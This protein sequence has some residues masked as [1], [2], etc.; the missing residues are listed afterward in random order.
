MDL[1]GF[2]EPEEVHEPSI[3]YF[4]GVDI[5]FAGVDLY[6]LDGTVYGCDLGRFDE[7]GTQR[8]QH[9]DLI[10]KICLIIQI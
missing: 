8:S 5:E 7:F 1:V 6:G 4:E 2:A 10:N 9:T 3:W